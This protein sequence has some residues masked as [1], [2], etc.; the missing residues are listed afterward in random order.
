V[1]SPE[2]VVELARLLVMEVD[3]VRV[4]ANAA[5]LVG[6]GPIR[7]ELV[8]IGQ[9]H[10]A[11]AEAL[12]EA[13]A[14]RGYLAP[15]PVSDA[16]GIVLGASGPAPAPPSPPEALLAIRRNELLVASL[17]AK[18]LAKR[19]PE[20]AVELLERLRGE[21]ERHRGWAERTLRAGGHAP[22]P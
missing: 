22:S 4:Y 10:E 16:A 3:A 9:E 7:D 1:Y 17:Y 15:D 20:G 11:H 18:V 21:A 6:P 5:S 14:F 19:P 13:I 12:R 8:L 2:L